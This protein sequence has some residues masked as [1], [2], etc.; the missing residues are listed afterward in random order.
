MKV[1]F[2]IPI[3]PKSVQGGFRFGNVKGR[4]IRYSD[5]T[6]REFQASVVNSLRSQWT[7]PPMTGAIK[8]KMLCFFPRPKYM[9]EAKY[10][11]GPIQHCKRPDIDD[12]AKG[13]WDCLGTGTLFKGFEKAGIIQDDSLIWCQIL[14]QFYCPT[15]EEPCIII[16][17]SETKHP[18]SKR[19]SGEG[20][21]SL[22]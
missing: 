15:D 12:V 4:T 5:K 3:T 14:K 10:G 21:D 18:D 16:E 2:K 1:K 7:K 9:T 6:K 17:L 22:L 8:A 13:I 11:S 19:P 20:I